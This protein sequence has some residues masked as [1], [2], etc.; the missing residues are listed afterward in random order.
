MFC[1][2]FYFSQ[3]AELFNF[4][5]SRGEDDFLIISFAPIHANAIIKQQVPARGLNN[6]C[7]S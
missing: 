6:Q 4:F 1:F 3:L 2:L 5:N 7:Y